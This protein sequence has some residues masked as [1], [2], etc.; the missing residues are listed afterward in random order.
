MN[1][2][3]L[4]LCLLITIGSLKAYSKNDY[5][6]MYVN[7]H[8][9]LN[10]VPVPTEVVRPRILEVPQ[11]L[12]INV[13]LS[14]DSKGR[15]TRARVVDSTDSRYNAEIKNAAKRWK[16]RPM[17][18]DGEPVKSKALVPFVAVT[19]DESLAMK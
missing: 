19:E 17:T 7:K 8:Q 1:R 10:G 15:V 14:I 12:K 2:R 18:K 9:D 16:F 5:E 6:Q 4:T 13:L 11:D 3:M